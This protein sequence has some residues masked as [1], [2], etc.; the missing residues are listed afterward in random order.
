MASMRWFAIVALPLVACTAAN[1]AFDLLDGEDDSAEA[2][3]G[4]DDAAGGSSEDGEGSGTGSAVECGP[5]AEPAVV[6]LAVD[7]APVCGYY[8]ATG[9]VEAISETEVHLRC[10]SEFD[11]DC[12]PEALAV[13]HIGYGLPPE[14]V[15]SHD[16]AIQMHW[17]TDAK[18]ELAMVRLQ[19][20]D[21]LRE[22]FIAAG[23]AAI[24]QTDLVP[25]DL[26][27]EM[28]D[29]CECEPDC[30]SLPQGRYRML[31]QAGDQSLALAE[32]QEADAETEGYMFR[33]RNLAANVVGNC[34]KTFHWQAVRL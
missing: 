12:L 31:K 21:E 28:E 7:G 10:N 16:R 2:Q 14:L 11:S 18:C 6:E 26:E 33:Y 15:I 34:R 32:G 24:F 4:P 1:P 13:L 5:F 17:Y 29:A 20:G 23:T 25:Y 22:S 27:A 3:D 8:V 30:C 19:Y 9:R